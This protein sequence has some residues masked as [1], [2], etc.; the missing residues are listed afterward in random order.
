MFICK[1]C[2]SEDNFQL[3][4]NP[5]YN[6]EFNFEKFYDKNGT[7]NIKIDD[8]SFIPDLNFMNNH[9]VCSYCGSIYCWGI[10]KKKKGSK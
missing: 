6:G 8:Y 9:A 7:I 4:V 2:K 5:I 10:N 3:L 1:K